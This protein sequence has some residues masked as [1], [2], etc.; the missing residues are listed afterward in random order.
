MERWTDKWPIPAWIKLIHLPIF[1]WILIIFNN[2][3][4]EKADGR[5]GQ[6]A[7]GQ[8]GWIAADWEVNERMDG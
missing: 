7:G 3:K 4:G 5:K 6:P 2:L 1:D 8:N